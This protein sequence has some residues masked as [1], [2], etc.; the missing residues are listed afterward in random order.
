MD[1]KIICRLNNQIS[2]RRCS[3]SRGKSAIRIPTKKPSFYQTR[4]GQLT[5]DHKDMDPAKILSKIEVHFKSR[6]LTQ[7]F[8]ER[9]NLS[10]NTHLTGNYFN[11]ENEKFLHLS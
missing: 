10:D 2:F 4:K 11:D 9:D 8:E 3:L 1:D 6:T 5:S 7:A